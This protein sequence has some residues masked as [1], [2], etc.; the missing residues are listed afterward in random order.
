MEERPST[1]SHHIGQALTE[2]VGRER[3]K[4]LLNRLYCYVDQAKYWAYGQMPRTHVKNLNDGSK[5]E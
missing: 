1:V 5:H 2:Q 4:N 3:A